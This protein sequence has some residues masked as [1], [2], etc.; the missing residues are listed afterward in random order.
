[1]VEVVEV[2]LSLEGK[3]VEC[4]EEIEGKCGSRTVKG[5]RIPTHVKQLFVTFIPWAIAAG[6]ERNPD[7]V[8]TVDIDDSN[9]VKRRSSG[10]WVTIM[11]E[12]AYETQRMERGA[13]KEPIPPVLDMS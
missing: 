12:V 10:T 11:P 9:V 7:F 3:F 5:C 1:M 2:E 13:V 8:P 6:T 4:L